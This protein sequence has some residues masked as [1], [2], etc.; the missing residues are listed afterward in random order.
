MTL[1]GVRAWHAERGAQL[2]AGRRRGEAGFQR[3]SVLLTEVDR[4]YTV[5][6]QNEM[7]NRV[8]SW[9]V[10]NGD[11]L[12]AL[13]VCTACVGTKVVHGEPCG[14][15]DGT[16]ELHRPYALNDYLRS[17]TF[18]PEREPRVLDEPESVTA[19]REV[20]EGQPKRNALDELLAEVDRLRS[21]LLVDTRWQNGYDSGY[22]AG[23]KDEG[24]RSMLGGTVLEAAP[25]P[26]LDD[27]LR[28]M[29]DLGRAMG[30]AM[31]L[32]R[33]TAA[34]LV[35]GFTAGARGVHYE[36]MRARLDEVMDEEQ[37]TWWPPD[38]EPAPGSWEASGAAVGRVLDEA[39]AERE[40][41]EPR[42]RIPPAAV[43]MDGVPITVVPEAA[44]GTAA[45]LLE[46]YR[47]LGNDV[48]DEGA[49]WP[50]LTP[51]GWEYRDVVGE[52][53]GD[54]DAGRPGLA[55]VSWMEVDP[56]H[57]QPGRVVHAAPPDQPVQILAPS[58][59]PD[60]PDEPEPWA[61]D[62]A[63][64]TYSA[65]VYDPAGWGAS[66]TGYGEHPEGWATVGRRVREAFD[67]IEDGAVCAPPFTDNARG[68]VPDPLETEAFIQRWMG[69]YRAIPSAVPVPEEWRSTLF[70]RTLAAVQQ[71]IAAVRE[72]LP[73][74]PNP[75]AHAP[76]LHTTPGRIGG[77]ATTRVGMGNSEA[78][79]I[80]LSGGPR[81][82][83]YVYVASSWRNTM[84]PAVIHLLRAAGIDCYDFRDPKGDGA[85][86]FSWKDV[87][88]EQ[89]IET[90][91]CGHQQ[92]EHDEGDGECWHDDQCT[93]MSFRKMIVAKGSDWVPADEY[94][95]MIE[96]PAALAGFE[97]DYA[98]MVKADTFV[99]VLPC[100]KSAHLEAGWA[101]GQGK[102]VVILLEDPVEP[103][104]MYR[105]TYEDAGTIVT[106]TMDLLAALGVQD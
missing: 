25:D 16:G 99:L 27:A 82:P 106:N 97:A 84:Q 15:C 59:E 85:G 83:E 12:G 8:I 46:R 44:P 93:C 101:M 33:A 1:E 104:L 92:V 56:L 7:T 65:T 60:E 58:E 70:T 13:V 28:Q 71:T 78:F 31:A 49:R 45:D 88:D 11:T 20:V 74:D 69:K 40:A 26:R 43:P 9:D 89:P 80:D 39:M 90:C 3:V 57:V 76:M 35:E 105:T 55:H 17:L 54:A 14:T 5:I 51:D 42:F 100:G 63:E 72:G 68:H 21:L 6:G 41:Q 77:V 48:W 94:L 67:P 18:T 30:K 103:E 4:L 29:H 2:R 86:G 61:A 102:R 87:R 66:V 53:Q 73:F 91:E 47:A 22:R 96:H 36:A 24:T 34:A 10:V 37:W 52:W 23:R 38:E 95:R 75:M 64:V 81:R 32:Q 62:G 50:L 98:A 79:G 19:I